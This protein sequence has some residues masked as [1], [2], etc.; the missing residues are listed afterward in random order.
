MPSSSHCA[1]PSDHRPRRSH[2]ARLPP[3]APP[4]HGSGHVLARPVIATS[5]ELQAGAAEE[6]A[7]RRQ[8]RVASRPKKRRPRAAPKS[9]RP[10]PRGGRERACRPK[11]RGRAEP[12]PPPSA[13]GATGFSAAVEARLATPEEVSGSR[14]AQRKPMLVLLRFPSSVVTSSQALLPRK[15][16]WSLLP[17]G[18]LDLAAVF[19][20][21]LALAHMSNKPLNPPLAAGVRLDGRGA[22]L[23]QAP[24]TSV[25]RRDTCATPPTE[26]R[27]VPL[28]LG[29]LVGMTGRSTADLAAEA[30]ARTRRRNRTHRTNPR[31]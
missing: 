8:A 12:S 29:A 21:L 1:P 15:G 26:Q 2:R 4:D 11:P 14:G 30:L 17:L 20:T 18:V 9:K 7:D 16:H 25:L 24:V 27:V 19:P 23:P 5:E 31:R 10:R 6:R 13:G 28:A 3:P 22:E